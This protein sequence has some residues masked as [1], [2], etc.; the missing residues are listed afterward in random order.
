MA[1]VWRAKSWVDGEVKVDWVTLST[2]TYE[3]MDV[4]WATTTRVL[5]IEFTAN[6]GS[7]DT[8]ALFWYNNYKQYV[9]SYTDGRTFRYKVLTA[10]DS[11]YTKTTASTAYDGTITL[12]AGEWNG[13]VVT[14]TRKGGFIKGKTYYIYVFAWNYSSTDNVAGILW[15]Y[16]SG[17]KVKSYESL[18]DFVPY[19]GGFVRIDNG[20]SFD[21]YM[22]YIDNGSSWDLYMPYIDNGSSWDMYGG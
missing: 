16:H 11:A 4:G 21:T 12:A 19:S 22:I 9:S 6:D 18:D 7:Y 15:G 17:N 20:S 8:I 2:S 3:F 13:K 10:E 14:F 5:E 1:N